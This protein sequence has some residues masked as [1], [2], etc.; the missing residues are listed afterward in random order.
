MKQ[1]ILS[2]VLLIGAGAATARAGGFGDTCAPNN[3]AYGR[4]YYQQAPAPQTCSPAAVYAQPSRACAVA[5]TGYSYEG[6]SALRDLRVEQQAVHRDFRIEQQ[7][8][9]YQLRLKHQALAQGLREERRTGFRRQCW[10]HNARR[11]SITCASNMMSRIITCAWRIR[12]LISN[13]MT[14]VW[15]G[16]RRRRNNWQAPCGFKAAGVPISKK[17]LSAFGSAMV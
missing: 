6:Q 7:E 14:V 4:S 13:C 10:W 15:A 5:P 1:I 16:E 8:L 3:Y 11:P 12:P 9:D 2:A 17:R